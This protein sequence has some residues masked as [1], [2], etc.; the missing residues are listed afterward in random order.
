MLKGKNAIVT[1]ATRGIGREI[2][3][4]LAA[5]GVNILINYR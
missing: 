5:L 2:A 3:K 4:K 1:G